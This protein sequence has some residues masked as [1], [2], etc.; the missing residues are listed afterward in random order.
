MP[1]DCDLW[2][3]LSDL[4]TTT[5]LRG[6]TGIHYWMDRVEGVQA[7]VDGRP[8]RGGIYYGS[9][10]DVAAIVCPTL[11]EVEMPTGVFTLSYKQ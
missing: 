4:I 2:E 9:K 11:P 7:V 1:K 3:Q 10:E 5:Q 8:P 6:K